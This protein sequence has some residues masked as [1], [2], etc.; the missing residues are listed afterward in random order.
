VSE[1]SRTDEATP[2]LLKRVCAEQGAL[3]Q[4]LDRYAAT[5]FPECPTKSSARKAIERGEIR[6]N[7]ELA[8]PYHRMREGDQVELLESLAKLPPVYDRAISVYYEDDSLAVVGKPPGIPVV[9]N[10][11]RTLLHALPANLLPSEATGAL[12]QP[13]PV[14]RLDWPTGGLV[15]VAKT[16]TALARLSKSFEMREVHKEYRAILK[17]RLEGQGRCESPIEGRQALTEYS[18]LACS[19]S[20]KS[21]WLT[22][23]RL[24]PHTGRKHQL[25]R[26]MSELGTPVLGDKT[27]DDPQR[28]L[29]GKGLFLWAVKL[30]FP[31]PVTGEVTRVAIDPPEK[32]GIVLQ[33]EARRW[34]SFKTGEE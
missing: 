10:L 7:G 31:H 23:V 4:R 3:G 34:A 19:R 25:R 2:L 14:H 27:Y 24:F 8:L 13:R 9:G 30:E 11:H 15:L 16:A 29:R 18:T 26:H 28:T 12:R 20:L 1:S 33:R 6:L 5:L 21:G 22:D 32:F 17:G